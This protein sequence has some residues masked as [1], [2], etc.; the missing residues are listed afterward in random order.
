V[1]LIKNTTQSASTISKVFVSPTDSRILI[2]GE[3]HSSPP[4]IIAN[5]E[6][7]AHALT[8]EHSV[9]PT[10]EIALEVGPQPIEVH[11]Q[12]FFD[13]FSQVQEVESP[14][15]DAKLSDKEIKRRW[16]WRPELVPIPV[17]LLQTNSWER[18]KVYTSNTQTTP[19]VSELLTT[20]EKKAQEQNIAPRI[21]FGFIVDQQGEIWEG[22]GVWDFNF[23]QLNNPLLPRDSQECPILVLGSA[24]N[25]PQ[26]EALQHLA[27][28][29]GQPP[30]AQ[31]HIVSVP[32]ALTL[33][34][35]EISNVT[36]SVKNTGWTTWQNS[37]ENQVVVRP[38]NTTRRSEVYHPDIWLD[39]HVIIPLTDPLV[40]P[41]AETEVTLAFKAPPYPVITTE[42]FELSQNNTGIQNSAFSVTFTIEGSGIGI[43]IL[44]TPTGFLNVRTQAS[45]A[46]ELIGAVYPG[47]RYVLLESQNDW[48]KI[49][50][51]DGTQGWVNGDYI[52]EL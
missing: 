2:D 4:I 45:L 22:F 11:I 52:K 37:G 36:I 50:L 32:T 43:E 16:Q 39:P 46:S 23:S 30:A 17:D 33:T 40:I 19:T 13:L 3:A 5:W 18:I 26:Q 48:H 41:G 31:A 35:E 20:F 51:S 42:T 7:G 28:F 49:R 6:P 10:T 47:E 1:A 9:L 29:I 12:L 34:T 15:V 8:I 38:Q 14:I 24:L 27:A 25:Q 21:P 44:D